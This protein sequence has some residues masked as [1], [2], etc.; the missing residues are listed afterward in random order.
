MDQARPDPG[1]RPAVAI[2]GAGSVAQALGRSM[3]TGGERVVALASRTLPRAEQ[4]ARFIG[5]DASPVPVVHLS[6][7]P[8]LASHVLIA[9]ADEGIRPVAETLASAG[10]ASGVALHTCGARGPEA[11]QPLRSAG[12]ACGLLHPLQTLMTPSQGVESLGLATFAV[13]GDTAATAWAAEIARV[14]THARTRVL[15]IDADRLP[16]Y[17]AGAV[18]ASNAIVAVLD[19]AA[20]LLTQAGVERSAALGALGPLAR[21][22]LAN[23][24]ENGPEAA[25]TGPVA[26]GDATTVAA[27][28]RALQNAA[29][30]VAALYDAASEHLLHL[31]RRRGLPESSMRAL[32]AALDITGKAR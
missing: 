5:G 30:S 25:L 15:R 24:L 2:V 17:H 12:V 27:H 3:V 23:A 18:M 4:A 16:Y 32:E 13:S 8:G 29:P 28:K 14:V 6:E 1:V 31:A 21:T 26:R 19:A 22:T 11:L 7:L 10:M 9:V 20:H